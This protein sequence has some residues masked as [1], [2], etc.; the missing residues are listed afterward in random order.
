[1]KFEFRSNKRKILENFKEKAQ[2]SAKN[3]CEKH[4]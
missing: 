2:T 3:F 1:M 4:Q